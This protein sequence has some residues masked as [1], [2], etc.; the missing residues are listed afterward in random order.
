MWPLR[1]E[2]H[3]R[4]QCQLPGGPA[5]GNHTVDPGPAQPLAVHSLDRLDA[6]R[7]ASLPRL[8]SCFKTGELPS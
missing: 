2:I 7:R 6:P 8:Q 4:S 5:P 3:V 1:I